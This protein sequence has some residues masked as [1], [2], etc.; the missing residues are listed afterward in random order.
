MNQMK[1]NCVMSEQYWC[2]HIESGLQSKTCWKNGSLCT[3]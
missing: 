2:T 3:T 1:L